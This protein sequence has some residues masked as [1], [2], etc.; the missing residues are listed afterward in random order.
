LNP[1]PIFRWLD[2]VL[3]TG[4]HVVAFNMAQRMGEEMAALVM[5]N[6]DKTSRFEDPTLEQVMAVVYQRGFG[7][8][9]QLSRESFNRDIVKI[10]IVDP[11]TRETQGS[12]VFFLA[13]LWSGIAARVCGTQCS[14]VKA[15]PSENALT[16]YLRSK[17]TESGELKNRSG[18]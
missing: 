4:G 18:D 5:K 14:F 6:N 12:F 17:K 8:A 11:P 7:H 13:G 10:H 9:V 1:T 3:G 2:D 16:L 15:Q